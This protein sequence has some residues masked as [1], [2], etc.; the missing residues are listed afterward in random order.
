MAMYAQAPA[1]GDGR[2]R[3]HAFSPEIE[4]RIK[5]LG[6][7]DNWHSALALA[8]DYSIILLCVLACIHVS[9][10]LYP[11]AIVLIGARQRGI[12]SI[13]H[14]CSHGVSARNPVLRVI[15]G[16]ILTAYP[17]FQTY[18]AYKISHVLTH[19]PQLGRE[20]HDADL[21]F[22]IEEGV[23][24][25]QPPHQFFW[26]MMV[27]PLL[28]W[29][30]LAYLRYLIRNRLSA[31]DGSS[32]LNISA[33]LSRRRRLEYLAFGAFWVVVVGLC[34][35]FSL[36]LYLVLF[37][38]I[39]YLTYFQIIGWYIELSEHCTVIN[40]Q[41]NDLF[42]ASNR[43]STGLERFLTGIHNDHHHLDH[44]LNPST[45][46]WNLPKARLIRL[47]DSEYAKVDKN[48]GGLFTR[49]FD[50]APSALRLLLEQ[51]RKRFEERACAKVEHTQP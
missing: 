10:W 29:R 21:Q 15:L 7:T 24:D 5:E 45:P 50:G 39:P 9:W 46:F 49:G 12:S 44:H 48:A 2:Y 22:F 32:E 47:Q 37:W 30:T 36:L 6:A 17:I 18:N 28:G 51:N 11:V 13:L 4:R 27:M 8:A 35:Y 40:G 3:R 42:M 19:H 23:F 33:D 34:V 41:S 16:T 14:E 26:R 20:N 43:H 38:I 1:L 31:R 25:P